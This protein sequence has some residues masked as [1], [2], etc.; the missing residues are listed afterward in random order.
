MSELGS[1]SKSEIRRHYRLTSSLF[2]TE[3]IKVN[4]VYTKPK[5]T[6]IASFFCEYILVKFVLQYQ[7]VKV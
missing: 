5:Q 1:S 6:D 4:V 3:E 2:D 7:H